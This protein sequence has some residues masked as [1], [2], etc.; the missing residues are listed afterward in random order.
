MPEVIKLLNVKQAVAYKR[1][2]W[3]C[4]A[5]RNS[6]GTQAVQ[7]PLPPPPPKKW[8]GSHRGLC[9][10]LSWQCSSRILWNQCMFSHVPLKRF[11][12]WSIYHSSLFC[13]LFTPEYDDIIFMAT[14]TS[15]CSSFRPCI[16]I[17]MIINSHTN[18]GI[19]H[20]NG[21]IH[22]PAE[23]IKTPFSVKCHTLPKVICPKIF[24]YDIKY[25]IWFDKGQISWYQCESGNVSINSV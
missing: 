8:L 23:K 12:F 17:V 6:S 1:W 11:L 9:I 18:L 10:S 13:L 7:L 14:L 15:Y 5:V 16:W 4:L 25:V 20:I 21:L 19:L 3:Y 24:L 2:S 22:S